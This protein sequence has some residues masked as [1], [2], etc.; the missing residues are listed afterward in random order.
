MYTLLVCAAIG[1][2]GGF[3]PEECMVYENMSGVISGIK[4]EGRLDELR[5]GDI[6]IFQKEH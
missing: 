4:V 5:V 1:S 2:G 6:V 3:T